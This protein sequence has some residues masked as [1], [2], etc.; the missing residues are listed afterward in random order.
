MGLIS[1][2]MLVRVVV[3]SAGTVAQRSGEVV[4]MPLPAVNV[5]PVSSVRDSGF[6]DRML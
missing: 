6:R 5:L 4:K 3:R 1:P 2:G